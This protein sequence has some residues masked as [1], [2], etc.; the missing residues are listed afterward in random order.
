MNSEPER[1]SPVVSIIVI[2]A[3]ITLIPFTCFASIFI[4]YDLSNADLS[5]N[6]AATPTA[7]PTNTVAAPSFNFTAE[8]Q[9]T[10]TSMAVATSQFAQIAD[11]VT[12]TP[13]PVNNQI[14]V[15]PTEASEIDPFL[16]TQT[17]PCDQGDVFDCEDFS[18]QLEAQSCWN[19]CAL[20]GRGDVHLLDVDGDTLACENTLFTTISAGI[21]PDSS[22]LTGTSTLPS[23]IEPGIIEISEETPTPSPPVT[24]PTPTVCPCSSNVLDCPDFAS[25]EEAQQC[26]NRCLR[27]TNGDVHD[28]ADNNGLAC[29]GAEAPPGSAEAD[30]SGAATLSATPEPVQ[31]PP[32]VP[33]TSA[34][35]TPQ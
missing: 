8:A 7:T 17:C 2:I 33:T 18:T 11:S 1:S 21:I 6:Q 26:Y 32:P 15:L 27:L 23:I 20:S 14:P 3:A 25:P 35:P 13:E 34:P 30:A 29:R 9:A 19:S 28:I 22:V 12:G 31:A 16:T 24:S 5:R 4:A 10:E